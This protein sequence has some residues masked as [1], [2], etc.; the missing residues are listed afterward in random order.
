MRL[1]QTVSLLLVLVLVLAY[2]L[3]ASAAAQGGPEAS[4]ADANAIAQPAH[5]HTG[6]C[7]TLGDVAYPLNDLVAPAVGTPVASPEVEDTD[8]G[9][10]NV[11]S[12]SNS[13][14]EASLDDL[15]SGEFAVNVHESPD[16]IQNYIACGD[17]FGSPDDGMLVIE[18]AELN[19]SGFKGKAILHDNGDGTLT[20]EIYLTRIDSATPAA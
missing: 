18:L 12:Y 15:T 11:V 10:E 3:F 6:S 13:T 19:G 14:V 1:R 5:I 20:V 17:I 8:S 4:P 2:G 16:E 9:L 7:A